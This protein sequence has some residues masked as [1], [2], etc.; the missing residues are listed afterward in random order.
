MG[1]STGSVECDAHNDL[2]R[3]RDLLASK[4]EG[5]RY[6][7]TMVTLPVLRAVPLLAAGAANR[8]R[9]RTVWDLKCL[10]HRAEQR[11]CFGL[12]RV[13]VVNCVDIHRNRLSE[14]GT[15]RLSHTGTSRKPVAASTGP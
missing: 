9:R 14:F 2:A 6:R 13:C 7:K 3:K 4:V 8:V 5:D 10:G 12:R 1:S 11:S 15:G